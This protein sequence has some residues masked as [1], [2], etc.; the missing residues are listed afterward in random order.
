MKQTPSDSGANSV[1][2]F[3]PTGK[4]VGI[5]NDAGDAEAALGD[6][7]AAGFRAGEL[8]LLV[9]EEAAGRIGTGGGGGQEVTVRVFRPTQRVPAFYDAPVIARRVEQE[10]RDGHYLIGVAARDTG[11]RA[12][13]RDILKSRGG[14][15]INFYG[16][17]AAEALEP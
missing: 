16:P 11:A 17:L 1:F 7:R 12:R 2:A 13:A 3:D 9:A 14:H 15:F 6:L 4:V 10:L 5:I 8:H